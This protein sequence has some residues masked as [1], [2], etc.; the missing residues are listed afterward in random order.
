MT[1]NPQ[2]ETTGADDSGRSASSR[3]ARTTMP[4]PREPEDVDSLLAETLRA[5]SEE[6]FTWKEPERK[7][8]WYERVEQQS[9]AA[10]SASRTVSP[11]SSAAPAPIGAPTA[12]SGGGPRIGQL[13]LGAACLLLAL[14]CLAALVFGVVL[15][16]LV[17]A[18][19]LCTLGGLA[20]IIAGLRPR[21]RRRL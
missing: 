3:D 19:G 16:P 8:R 2:N 4:L 10:A 15:D 11:T 13:L 17:V 14:W 6:H 18:L 12:A 5:E 7:P 21:R 20:L 1:T 9:P